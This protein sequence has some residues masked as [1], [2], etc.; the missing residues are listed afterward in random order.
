MVLLLSNITDLNLDDI[1]NVNVL[2][3]PSASAILGSQA[4]NGA[5]IITTKKAK[6]SGGKSM[7]IELNSGFMASSVYILPGYQNDYAGGNT[8]DMY[9]YTYRETDPD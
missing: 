8:Y 7:G 9:K 5:I 3:G 6:V 2:S 1:D 4:A